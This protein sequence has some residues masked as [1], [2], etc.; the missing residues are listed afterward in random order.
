MPYD[1]HVDIEQI[2]AATLSLLEH[3][4]YEGKDTE[5]VAELKQCLRE[6]ISTVAAITRTQN[7][8]KPEA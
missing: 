6:T 3:A 7:P 2:L 5:A 8:T 4:A 1:C